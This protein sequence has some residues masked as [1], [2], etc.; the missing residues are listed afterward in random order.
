MAVDLT[1]EEQSM[2]KARS[3]LALFVGLAFVSYAQ[4]GASE[5]EDC[6]R[7][8]L[9]V[10]D[11]QNAYLSFMS[12]EDRES[13]IQVTNDAIRFFHQHDLPV[14]RVYNSDLRW[15]PKEGS[16]GFEYSKKVILFE[17]DVRIIK[18][19][20]NAF[21]KTGLDSVLRKRGC[22]TLFLCGLSATGCLLA[23]YFGGIERGYK[24]SLVREGIMSPR[25]DYTSV[26]RD[27]CESVGEQSMFSIVAGLKGRR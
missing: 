16:E 15:G 23:T 4:Q 6:M 5:R 24:T 25:T 3:S 7:P 13:A 11:I 8:A 12:K 1:V 2:N 10:I 21:T 18:H 20:P 22:N 14:I 19:F 27:I 9:L 17:D 26:I